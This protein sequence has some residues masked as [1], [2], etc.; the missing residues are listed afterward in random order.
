MIDR[1][2]LIARLIKSVTGEFPGIDKWDLAD[3]VF[4]RWP[5]AESAS[6]PPNEDEVFMV[7]DRMERGLDVGETARGSS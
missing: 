1:M 3:T 5:T 2:K 7:A 4:E 6:D